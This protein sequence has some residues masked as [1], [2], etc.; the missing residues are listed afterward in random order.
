MNNP[1]FNFMNYDFA[2]VMDYPAPHKMQ[3]INLSN[4]LNERKIESI[5]WGIGKYN[6]QRNN[7]YTAEQY[8][9]RRNIHIGIDIWTKAESPVYSFYNGT[10]QYVANNAQPGDYGPTLVIAYELNDQTFYALYGHLSSMTIANFSIGETVKKGQQIATIGVEAVNGGWPPHLHFQLSV[11]DPGQ[12]DMPG[13]VAE[14]NHEK[15]L[16]IYPD[17]RLVLGDLY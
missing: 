16:E 3:V 8:E 7:M 10:V 1:D 12:A 13:V 11:E 4:G 9:G 17:P 5:A 2:P 15:A 14:D 6:E